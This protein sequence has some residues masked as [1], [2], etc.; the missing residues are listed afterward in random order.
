MSNHNQIRV[1]LISASYD[2][3][4]YNKLF[5][6]T[7]KDEKN[8]LMGY[9]K[10]A[11]R[12]NSLLGLSLVKKLSYKRDSNFSLLH[13]ELGQPYLVGSDEYISIS[14][15]EDTIVVAMSTNKVG[16]DVEKRLLNMGYE[17]FLADEEYE[18]F[19]K[20]KNKVDL[21][22]TLWTLKESYVKLKGTGFFIDPTIISFN[23]IE[24]RWFLKD[25]SCT[26]Y[27]ENLPNDMKLSIA[28]EE[29]KKITFEKIT[30]NELIECLTLPLRA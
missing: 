25:V 12:Y 29:E 28:S 17:S 6:L 8:Y 11:D 15:S 27:L 4:V 20:S 21:L 10:L 24:D 19:N 1:C 30:E 9:K 7:N 23:K 26:F 18:L 2:L 22:T 14:H 16:I 5:H 3:R 13:N